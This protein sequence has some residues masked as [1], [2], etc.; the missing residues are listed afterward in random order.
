MKGRC[1]CK[2]ENLPAY[3][4]QMLYRGERAIGRIVEC[5]MCQERDLEVFHSTGER[6][7]VWGRI[8][9]GRKNS[10]F[11]SVKSVYHEEKKEKQAP[12]SPRQDSS[13]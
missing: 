12:A 6:M 10:G 1:R 2:E 8:V 9:R 3:T 5:V 7:P 4:M 11:S 13:V